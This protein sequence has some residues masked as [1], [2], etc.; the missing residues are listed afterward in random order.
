MSSEYS[1]IISNSIIALLKRDIRRTTFIKEK[2][3]GQ[4]LSQA[5]RQWI[6]TE[7]LLR[8]EKKALDTDLVRSCPIVSLVQV[9]LLPSIECRR[10]ASATWICRRSSTWKERTE[11][12]RSIRNSGIESDRKYRDWG[13]SASDRFSN[14]VVCL[15]VQYRSAS[16][17]I[18]TRTSSPICCEDSQRSLYVLQSIRILFH[19]LAIAFSTDFSRGNKSR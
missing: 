17:A 9:R 13:K 16:S 10:A 12:N 3:F 11:I 18:P 1:E 14:S 7:C 4:Q 2:L 6:W 19:L 15:D 8:F 5:L